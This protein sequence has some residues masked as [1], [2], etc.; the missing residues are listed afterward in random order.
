MSRRFLID[1]HVLL[2]WAEGGERL[3]ALAREAVENPEHTVLVSAA[4][5]WELGLKKLSGKLTT[6]QDYIG[7]LQDS[8]FLPLS[9]SLEH[10]IK[11]YSLPPVH[12]DP[13]DRML[14]AQAVVEQA[15]LITHDS[16]LAGYGVPT[17]I[18]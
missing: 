11:A 10:A 17:L 2:W 1:S 4:S 7:L 15:T 5:I 16:I 9:V 18:A 13:F 3:S 6:P 12:K 8:R 14:V